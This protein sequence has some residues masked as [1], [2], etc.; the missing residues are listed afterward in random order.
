MNTN[1]T[2]KGVALI[3][4][5]SLVFCLMGS[6][7][8][9]ASNIDSYIITLVR[10][11]IGLAMLG[12]AA[13]FGIIKL[14]FTNSLFLLFRGL[15]GGTATFIFFL[16][17]ARLGIAKAAVIC[18]S[19]PIFASI[20][21]FIFLKER[22][23][24]LKALA[25]LTAF[26]GLYLLT[27]DNISQAAFLADFGKY[28]ALALVGA[29][30][31]GLSIVLIKKLHDTDSSFA[32]YFAQCAIGFW[33]LIIPANAASS[34]IGYTG[35]FVLLCIGILGTAG[36]L[37]MTQGYKYVP[38]STGAPLMLIVP[39]LSYAIG[40]TAFQEVLSLRSF[41]GSAIVLCCCAIVITANK[42]DNR[43]TI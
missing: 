20:F 9:Y 16:A 18:Y 26:A 30:L 22:I 34:D 19:F 1:P 8:K 37:L 31:G 40:V 42:V 11:A 32:I 14:R 29:I 13:L 10:F 33:L 28:E 24:I 36:Q 17:I 7:I 23:G 25:I 35:A 2:I 41:L 5:A 39:V 6:L 4:T 12:T 15:T 38:V 43:K 3:V 21:G 27:T